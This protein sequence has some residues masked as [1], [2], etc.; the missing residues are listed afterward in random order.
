MANKG[1]IPRSLSRTR[2]G[3]IWRKMLD[4]CYRKKNHNYRYYGGLGTYVC[5]RWR[6]SI[7][8]FIEDMGNAPSVGH[9]L[10]RI[11]TFGHYT[12][13][14]CDE[15]QAKGQPANCRWATKAEQARNAKNNLW[16]THDGKTL[17]LKDWARLLGTPYVKLWLRL[18]RYDIPFAEAI[19]PGSR[20]GRKRNPRNH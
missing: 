2:E 12:C 11:N 14:R 5:R 13:G 20:R 19:L 15:C 3:G 8:A 7:M 4:R 16:F 9:T 6:E 17:I 10:D 18:F 1:S